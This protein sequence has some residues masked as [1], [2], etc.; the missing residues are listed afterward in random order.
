M[1][2]YQEQIRDYTKQLSLSHLFIDD[3]WLTN[4]YEK[5][6]TTP[7]RLVRGVLTPHNKNLLCDPK[8]PTT[9]ILFKFFFNIK[10]FETF[11]PHQAAPTL[12]N[13]KRYQK[14]LA[15]QRFKSENDKRAKEMFTLKKLK[16]TFDNA[17]YR[18][19]NFKL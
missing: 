6:K 11:E 5:T 2:A 17:S 10:N 18:L 14:R 13:I 3:D 8:Q 16:T 7:I 19:N 1:L 9:S 12:T 15:L 4:K